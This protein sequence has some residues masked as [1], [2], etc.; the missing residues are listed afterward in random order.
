MARAEQL[1][2]GA[3]RGIDEGFVDAHLQQSLSQLMESA[4]HAF[5]RGALLRASRRAR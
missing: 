4:A 3:M 1:A 5:A 2:V